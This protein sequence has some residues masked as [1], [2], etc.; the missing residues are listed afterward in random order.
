MSTGKKYYELTDYPK[1]YKDTYWGCL[2]DSDESPVA[3]EI[4]NSRNE[5]ISKLK[6][7]GTSSD[8]GKSELTKGRDD[9]LWDHVEVYKAGKGYVMITSPYDKDFSVKRPVSTLVKVATCLDFEVYDD[10]YSCY[11]TTY[12]RQFESRRECK[13]FCQNVYTAST[14]TYPVM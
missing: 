11:T 9:T 1:I 7:T 6:I 5:F 13:L 3:D 2:C 14:R 10:L 12:I 8:F 4:I